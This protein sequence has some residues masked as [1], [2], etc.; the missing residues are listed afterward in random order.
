MCSFCNGCAEFLWP[1]CSI[2]RASISWLVPIFWIL[3]G[4]VVI[5]FSLNT[6]F[7]LCLAVNLNTWNVR[8]MLWICWVLSIEVWWI[9]FVGLIILVVGTGLVTSMT[10]WVLSVEVWCIL[11]I[12]FSDLCGFVCWGFL[13]YAATW[14]HLHS[15]RNTLLNW[16]AMVKFVQWILRREELCDSI[17]MGPSPKVEVLLSADSVFQLQGFRCD[18]SDQTF[19]LM[20]LH[21]IVASKNLVLCVSGHVVH[22]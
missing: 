13:T 8:C 3:V 11:L 1:I 4:L 5:Q 9:F 7:R 20:H 14:A 2:R 18:I 12:S 17:A 15:M 16:Y 21:V 19:L 22:Q 6:V 10:C